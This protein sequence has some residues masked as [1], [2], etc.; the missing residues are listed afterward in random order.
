MKLVKPSYFDEVHQKAK[1]RWE[2][3]DADPELAAPWHQLFK[4]VQS[5]RH[6]ISELLQNAD[7][8]EATDVEIK[9]EDGRFT[10]FHNGRDFSEEEL[11]SLCRFGYSN[12]RMLRTIGFRGVGF[13]STFSL[14]E[15]VELN[16]PT[17]SLVFHKKWFTL[18]VWSESEASKDNNTHILVKITENQKQNELLNNIKEWP[19]SPFSLLF[20]NNIRRLKL[21]TH[22]LLWKNLGNGPVA[23][24]I[25][26]GLQGQE[27]HY[28][29]VR[30][31]DEP[32]PEDALA[33]IRD[34][35]LLDF[36]ENNS[37][38]PCKVEIVLGAPGNL[39]VVLPTGVKTP[40]PF[41]INAPFI[42]DPARL[43]IK[44]P[45][46]SPTNKWL[47]QRIGRLAADTMLEWLQREDLDTNERAKA[48]DLLPEPS[49]ADNSLENTCVQ[50]IEDAFNSTIEGKPYILSDNSK[51]ELPN[52][53]ISVPPDLRKIWTSDQII[54]LLVVKTQ[55]PCLLSN[56][57][58]PINSQKLQKYHT[59]LSIEMDEFLDRLTRQMPP[60]P[61]NWSSLLLL[62]KMASNYYS[63]NRELNLFPVRGKSEL[64]SSIKV[65]R[66]G[67]KKLL[68]SDDDW[69][70]LATY[71]LV[72]DVN[73]LRYLTEQRRISIETKNHDLGENV[74]AADWFLQKNG[75]NEPGNID[76]VIDKVAKVFF[77]QTSPNLSDCI[78]FT[79]IAA[80]LNAKAGTNFRFVTRDMRIS[81]TSASL[82]FDD[83][84][85]LE[86]FI[87]EIFRNELL[88][89][90]GYTQ[91]YT[92][93]TKDDWLQWI[94]SG[95]SGIKTLI[96]ISKF[97]KTIYGNG[98]IEKEVKAHGFVGELYYR[99]NS[100]HFQFDDLDFGDGY[101]RY[102]ETCAQ[103]DP[104][105]WSG[106]VKNILFHTKTPEYFQT[107]I[108]YQIANNGYYNKLT[109]EKMLPGWALKLRQLPC[110][111]D[112]RG[113]YHQPPE[114]MR[115]T[116]QTE[117][118]MDVEPF[119]DANLDNEAARPLLDLLGV[120]S[121]ITGPQQIIDRL[122]A[123][124]KATRPPL[125]E[126][127]KWYQRL[128]ALFDNCSTEDQQEIR[129]VFQDENLI[130]TEDGTWETA[131]AAYIAA[132]ENDAPGAALIH[133]DAA[134]L[135]MWRKI[136]VNERPT[137]DLA[138]KW[139]KGLPTG[140]KLRQADV[141]RVK[142]L[143][144][145]H[146]IQIWQ[147]CGHWLNLAGEWVPIR[148]LQYYLSMQSLIRWSN[149]HD[150]VKSI[151][152]DL[153]MLN[154]E[155]ILEQPFASLSSLASQIKKRLDSPQIFGEE[156]N[157]P[158]LLTLAKI[159]AHISL[160]NN[161][162]TAHIRRLATRLAEAEY[163]RVGT[164]DVIPYLNGKPAGLP[165]HENLAWVDNVIYITYIPKAR[166]IRQ[167][168]ESLANIFDW[169]DLKMILAYAFERK[170]E[171][172]LAY[173]TENYILEPENADLHEEESR[174][175]SSPGVKNLTDRIDT[176]S[177]S[178]DPSLATPSAGTISQ[179][180]IEGTPSEDNLGDSSIDEPK[181]PHEP[182][183][184]QIKNPLIE[185]FAK[186]RGFHK[187]GSNQFVNDNGNIIMK[188]DGVFPWQIL[189]KD[190]TVLR[191]Y[192]TKEH[193]LHTKPLEIPTEI[194]NLIEANPDQ[195]A[196]ILEDIDGN[197]MEML[198]KDL[199][200]KKEIGTLKLFPATYRLTLELK[201]RGF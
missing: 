118:L 113:N 181:P 1:K 163:Q 173:M 197:P 45:E 61:K 178:E 198:G 187:N 78:R 58:S 127:T 137:V 2:Q 66:L 51:L 189:E 115:R 182:R 116:P 92:S 157:L 170:E 8:A 176:P 95:N 117:P 146:P 62:W 93:C 177:G 110:L 59:I 86:Q 43:K 82:L 18:P 81:P 70:F 109:N 191:Y 168:S 131:V 12:K 195:H 50:I 132:N 6:V 145:R 56:C 30:S 154:T 135:S 49:Q 48:Y 142:T 155:T 74:D 164:L 27:T 54:S 96:P 72:L 47:L 139:L 138:I 89:N 76:I 193:C 42:Q 37:L 21:G 153:I 101:W 57:V 4:Q 192:W 169:D 122:R 19:N 105:F 120:R 128:D 28:L 159:L 3:L 147:S 25:W 172:I 38:P 90:D 26:M 34:E 79:Q 9:V 175:S 201:D 41:A 39:F 22:E 84:G 141:G 83:T 106:L 75:L 199:V 140:E 133:S 179:G 35:R 166:L 151:T 87:P 161:D 77:T 188:A 17:L 16:T 20:F 88:I 60:R 144:G 114:L 102:W 94:H 165:E 119:I 174:G 180:T 46:I 67:E 10:F 100:N 98:T 186:F 171:D 104:T 33:E 148:N 162:Q 103:E 108:A 14:G 32:F 7:D 167:I 24:S 36:T 71:L 31:I 65:S 5:P 129:T 126:L 196:F 190:G 55:N 152:A 125:R 44:D 136:G 80:K 183:A 124:S 13:K 149:L 63:R 40:L 11:N 85:K 123:L 68:Q 107:P 160:E 97:G 200:N 185:R 23:N 73:W 29:I 130:Y 91:I 143:L 156:I 64:F 53:C 158:W 134:Q 121:T 15:T 69:D 111:R 52:R 194:W 150:W 112:T 99:Y 184:P